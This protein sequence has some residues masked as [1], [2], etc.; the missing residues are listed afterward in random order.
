MIR[1]PLLQPLLIVVAEF[2]KD[3]HSD[4]IMQHGLMNNRTD[5]LPSAIL[6]SNR[7]VLAFCSPGSVALS[8][9]VQAASPP[10]DYIEWTAFCRPR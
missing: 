5:Y 10:K 2:L 1:R 6:I 9:L 7:P 4:S 8:R 3:T